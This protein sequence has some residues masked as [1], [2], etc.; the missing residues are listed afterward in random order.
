MDGL[1]LTIPDMVSNARG[2]LWETN[3]IDRDVFAVF[4]EEHIY[5]YVLHRE[6]LQ[7]GV[8]FHKF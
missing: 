3:L 2:L 8:W 7:G 6:S 4:D 5:T 1:V